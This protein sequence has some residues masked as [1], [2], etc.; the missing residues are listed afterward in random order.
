MIR[1]DFRFQVEMAVRRIGLAPI[2]GQCRA[3][4]V[5]DANGAATVLTSLAD[6]GVVLDD[7]A[8]D[9]DRIRARI[10]APGAAPR[11]F[12]EAPVNF[13]IIAVTNGL[14]MKESSPDAKV[15]PA[16]IGNVNFGTRR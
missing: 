1:P 7:K 16:G 14:K 15:A 8:H 3:V 9:A 2:A 5:H 13:C 4:R 10:E 11:N 12:A 6:G